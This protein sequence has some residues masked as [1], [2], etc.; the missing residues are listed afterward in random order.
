LKKKHQSAIAS[1]IIATEK[2][3]PAAP[4]A[5]FHIDSH[6]SLSHSSVAIRTM[7]PFFTFI[8]R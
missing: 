4:A 3:L 6:A 5:H 2:E 1:L 8:D 7:A